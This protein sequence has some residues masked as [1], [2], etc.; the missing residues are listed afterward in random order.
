M[1]SQT[2]FTPPINLLEHQGVDPTIIDRLIAWATTYGRYIMVGTEVVVLLAFISRFSLD[3]RL[4]DLREEV[5]QKQLILEANQTFETEFRQTQK[6]LVDLVPILD[7]ITEFPQ[8]LEAL[9]ERT[10][11]DI[12]LL[13]IKYAE[14]AF[15]LDAKARS[16]ESMSIFLNNLAQ[17]PLITNVSL[18]DVDQSAETGTSF[19]VSGSF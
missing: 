19:K 12:T 1:P 4:T 6:T 7:S 5:A 16:R 11:P 18:T 17:L 15:I 3:R 10:P 9:A 13:D 8:L 2:T 14:G